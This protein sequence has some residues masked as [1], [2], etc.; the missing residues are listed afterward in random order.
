MRHFAAA[1]A[2]FGLA[3]CGGQGGGNQAASAGNGAASAPAAAVASGASAGLPMQPGA[4]EMAIQMQMP[5]MP[6][7]VRARIAQQGNITHRACLTPE[8]LSDANRVFLSGG[9][10]LN[11]TH[12][13]S[14]G[15]RIGGGRIDGSVSCTGPD[16]Q[17]TRITMNGRL[18]AT[19]YDLDQHIQGPRGALASHVVAHRVGDC[20]PQE[21]AEANGDRP[22]AGTH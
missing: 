6:P 4:W 19:E 2:A 5:D 18:G 13:D 20:T 8:Q 22:A 7:E 11:G 12:C 10:D 14:S 3:A 16:G 17:P 15:L 1:V 21:A 9:S